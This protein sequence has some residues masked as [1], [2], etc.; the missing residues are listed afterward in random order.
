MVSGF[1]P[2]R[3]LGKLEKALASLDSLSNDH[4]PV[5][6]C[7]GHSFSR[8]YQVIPRPRAGR[9]GLDLPPACCETLLR[10]VKMALAATRSLNRQ[11]VRI[12]KASQISTEYAGRSLPEPRSQH[13]FQRGVY[14]WLQALTVPFLI[15]Y[16][17]DRDRGK[18]SGKKDVLP[19][20][21]ESR[22][23]VVKQMR[24]RKLKKK[25]KSKEG[26]ER[27]GLSWEGGQA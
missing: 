21:E 18:G 13:S 14:R 17:L 27:M 15:A 7:S 3:I 6:R 11:T 20:E 5:F 12:V 16:L 9:L 10:R 19:A 23:Y 2:R 4:A 25:V 1:D 8:T 24:R 26:T 22:V